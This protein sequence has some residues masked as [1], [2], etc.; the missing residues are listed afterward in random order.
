MGC[1]AFHSSG[2]APGYTAIALALLIPLVQAATP[3]VR[4]EDAWIRW[5]PAGVPAAGYFTLVNDSAGP[6]TLIAAASADFGDVTIHR[7][8][9]HAGVVE[10]EPVREIR[11]NPHSRLDL[12]A[13][14]YH[15][16]LTSPVQ[17]IDARKEISITLKFSDGS[18]L[19]APFQVRK[20]DTH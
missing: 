13:L 11:L 7:S 15:L 3:A 18:W 20:A 1:T 19:V 4:I 9:E 12:G 17:P 5:L 8:V 14:G 6:V 2:R 16:M 10:M